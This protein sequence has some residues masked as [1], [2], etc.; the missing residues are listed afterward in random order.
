ML[1]KKLTHEN[2][3]SSQDLP[4]VSPARN[5]SPPGRSKSLSKS[6]SR[7]LSKSLPSTVTKV[8]PQSPPSCSPMPEGAGRAEHAATA[9]AAL[10]AA[11]TRPTSPALHAEAGVEDPAHRCSDE[12]WLLCLATHPCLEEGQRQKASHM[13]PLTIAAD[14]WLLDALVEGFL[15]LVKFQV[16]SLPCAL[17][18]A[19]VLWRQ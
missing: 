13:E 11:N 8:S 10:S 12:L 6:L 17:R 15:P 16:P 7:S 1:G 14:N 9:G 2:P 19:P 5:F 3:W 18:Y 4:K